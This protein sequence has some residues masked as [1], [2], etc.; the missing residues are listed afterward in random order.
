MADININHNLKSNGKNFPQTQTSISWHA[1]AACTA[2]FNPS[3]GNCFGNVGSI[4]FPPDNQTLPVV[5]PID[6]SFSVGANIAADIYDIT[7][8]SPKPKPKPRPKA[9]AV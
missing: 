7:F 6:T 3:T 5:S 8:T 9:A 2:T 1:D 4:S